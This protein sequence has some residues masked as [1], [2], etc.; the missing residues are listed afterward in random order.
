MSIAPCF[1]APTAAISLRI[2]MLA[3]SIDA[4]DLNSIHR[5]CK[6]IKAL[7]TAGADLEVAKAEGADHHVCVQTAVRIAAFLN[8][9]EDIHTEIQQSSELYSYHTMSQ[10]DRYNHIKNMLG[11][12]TQN[13]TDSVNELIA[14]R[15]RYAADK[16]AQATKEAKIHIEQLIANLKGGHVKSARLDTFNIRACIIKGADT[17]E[18]KA[19]SE[20]EH[21]QWSRVQKIMKWQ[22][23]VRHHLNRAAELRAQSDFTDHRRVQVSALDSDDRA[24]NCSN[25]VDAAISA[26]SLEF[27]KHQPKKE[28]TMKQ[29]TVA[30]ITAAPGH[31][32]EQ[33]SATQVD[34]KKKVQLT[35]V[36][37]MVDASEEKPNELRTRFNRI[38]ETAKMIRGGLSNTAMNVLIGDL[39]FIY[40]GIGPKW[41]LAE[42]VRVFGEKG[43]D[44]NDVMTW[45]RAEGHHLFWTTDGDE[46]SA[47]KY[48]IQVVEMAQKFVDIIREKAGLRKL[49]I[50]L[51][52]NDAKQDGA[53][54]AYRVERSMKTSAWA[55]S[56]YLGQGQ[57]SLAVEACVDI[58]KAILLCPD[59][60]EFARGQLELY[61]I[62]LE[63]VVDV[64]EV[65]AGSKDGGL[66]EA[67]KVVKSLKPA[68]KSPTPWIDALPTCMPVQGGFR[69]GEIY[70]V[71]SVHAAPMA[72]TR[73]TWEQLDK[74]LHSKP[75]TFPP[76]K[77]ES[78]ESGEMMPELK[79]PGEL[80]NLTWAY[81]SVLCKSGM[82]TT[83][84][85][86]TATV[87]LGLIR[88]GL[89]K[90]DWTREQVLQAFLKEGVPSSTTCK[91]LDAEAAYDLARPYVELMES[92]GV[93]HP[94]SQTEMIKSIQEHKLSHEQAVRRFIGE[95]VK[96]FHGNFKA[97]L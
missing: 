90:K 82:F 11:E 44:E 7:I 42:V 22:D 71:S 83:H 79:I 9:R 68:K 76:K 70:V 56:T 66:E 18:L 55:L 45:V 97:K 93:G 17:R 72:P 91:W 77:E 34:V 96:A 74:I 67:I 25:L 60:Q 53:D 49:V 13:I 59:V 80:S 69:P 10:R 84:S 12:T 46:C 54:V 23:A 24:N 27:I 16:A 37:I 57:N 50:R 73:M 63:K 15:Q 47:K 26:L 20:E 29:E 95:C 28:E 41:D 6:Q 81:K 5:H 64:V 51:V 88:D 87:A 48:E 86:D 52:H 19:F 40:S 30:T 39:D 4:A 78:V 32:L 21:L 85:T 62:S 61:G 35:Q 65:L 1:Q 43:I 2:R 36:E 58:A 94:E 31:T 75:S 89:T 38:V 33:V 3:E 92:K 8:V 14:A